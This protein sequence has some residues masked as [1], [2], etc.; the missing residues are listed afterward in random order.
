MLNISKLIYFLFLAFSYANNDFLIGEFPKDFGW[1]ACS[2]AYQTEGAWNVDGK[3]F[4]KITWIMNLTFLIPYR[5][6]IA[7]YNMKYISTKFK[8]NKNDLFVK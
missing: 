8:D 7:I 3:T 5:K 6:N 1:G 4:L 2:S